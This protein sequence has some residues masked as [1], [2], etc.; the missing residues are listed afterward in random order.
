[1]EAA[2]PSQEAA[3]AGRWAGPGSL[4]AVRRLAH[5]HP[6]RPNPRTRSREVLPRH[7]RAR[8]PAR[9]VRARCGSLAESPPATAAAPAGTPR[10][11]SA[12]GSARVRRGSARVRRGS[13]RVRRGSARVRRGSA[14][15]RPSRPP[16]HDRCVRGRRPD[17]RHG[18]RHRAGR[19][20]PRGRAQPGG[21]VRRLHQWC[22]ARWV[23]LA[24][25][26]RAGPL[27]QGPF[28]TRWGLA[29]HHP[30]PT[31]IA[32]TPDRAEDRRAVPVSVDRAPRADP[33]ATGP[34]AG[35]PS[36]SLALAAGHV[37]V[38]RRATA[39]QPGPS[40]APP[41]WSRGRAVVATAAAVADVP[42][43]AVALPSRCD[44][45]MP[46]S[47]E[48]RAPTGVRPG[49]AGPPAPRRGDPA[50]TERAR[51]AAPLVGAAPQT[52]AAVRTGV[53]GAPGPGPREL[54]Q[55]RGASRAAA[56]ARRAA[57]VFALAR[58]R[59]VANQATRPARV[60]GWRQRS[61]PREV[62]SSPETSA[63]PG[64]VS[65]SGEAANRTPRLRVG[66]IAREGET[67]GS[68]A[69]APRRRPGRTTRSATETG[70]IPAPPPIACR[71]THQRPRHRGRRTALSAVPTLARRRTAGPPRW[72]AIR[73]RRTG[74]PGVRTEGRR[75][76]PRASVP[77]TSG[78]LPRRSPS[79]PRDRR[80][81][82]D[83]LPCLDRHAEAPP[84]TPMGR[85]CLGCPCVGPSS[86]PRFVDRPSE[87]R[88]QVRPGAVAYRR[89]GVRQG[90]ECPTAAP[91]T[92][93]GRHPG[94]RQLPVGPAAAGRHRTSSTPCDQVRLRAAWPPRL[95]AAWP[96]SAD[97]RPRRV[98]PRAG[99]WDR[100]GATLPEGV[101]LRPVVARRHRGDLL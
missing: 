39:R 92:L 29:A 96:R 46:L 50:P 70:R 99:H 44:R 94:R 47:A 8:A 67:T 40:P 63:R 31:A 6:G 65:R 27:G 60:I 77:R 25:P 93:E 97:G 64:V 17:R 16:R 73:L 58:R 36:A 14:P 80:L 38:A 98:H 83:R 82:P 101:D 71:C 4:A 54:G 51:R 81:F 79:G 41:L 55:A 2:V 72:T 11:A 19:R 87:G 91:R 37:A 89:S 7:H 34:A 12:Q 10:A 18:R 56:Q 20:P 30:A 86:P 1:V 49:E 57:P 95:G 9:E 33:A 28:A 62:P 85:Q 78:L 23:R 24:R 53:A 100:R 69:G 26:A 90:R 88:P 52:L 15:R 21:P 76:R 84:P 42:A 75:P 68:G 43:R 13:A 35:R 22:R 66:P 3:P 61:R 48:N 5:P 74:V 45:S 32:A 59:Q